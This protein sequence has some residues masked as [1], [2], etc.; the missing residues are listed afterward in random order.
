MTVQ[1]NHTIV[2][3]RDNRASAQFF[4]DMFGL[5]TPIRYGPFYMVPFSNDSALEFL[6]VDD[7]RI[8]SQHYAFLVSETEFD[9][10]F[11]RVQERKLPYWGGPEHSAP[12]VINRWNGGRGV[13]FDDPDGHSLEIITRPYLS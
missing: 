9:E 8:R 3:A 4:V 10:I 11:G 12:G 13:Y 2:R 1:L 6:T 7:E 5:P